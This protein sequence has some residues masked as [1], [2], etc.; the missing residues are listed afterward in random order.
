MSPAEYPTAAARIPVSSV[1]L[2]KA[3]TIACNTLQQAGTGEG[4]KGRFSLLMAEEFA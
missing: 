2:L 3:D 1:L 4:D